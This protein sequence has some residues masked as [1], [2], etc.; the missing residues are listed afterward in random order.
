MW[1]GLAW[2]C[3]GN[4]E[5]R[6]R[7][8]GSTLQRLIKSSFRRIAPGGYLVKKSI[9]RKFSPWQKNPSPNP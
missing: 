2:R 9:R 3:G 6:S 8:Q 5:R 4:R 1:E 7:E